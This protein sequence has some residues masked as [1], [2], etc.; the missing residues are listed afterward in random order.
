M[1]KNSDEPKSDV[2]EAFLC[3]RSLNILT[4]KNNLTAP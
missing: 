3:G 2:M 4:I 1:N